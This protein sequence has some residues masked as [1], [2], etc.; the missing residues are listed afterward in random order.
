MEY[1]VKIN[2]RNLLHLSDKQIKKQ[3]SSTT[4]TGFLTHTEMTQRD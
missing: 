2:L 4:A 1:T 3:N